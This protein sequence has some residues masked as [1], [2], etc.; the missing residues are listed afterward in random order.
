MATQNTQQAGVPE[1]DL[2]DRLSKSLRHAG[3]GTDE[4]AEHLGVDRKTVGNYKGGRTRPSVA[5]LR[6]WAMRCGVPFDWLAHGIIDDDGPDGPG[7]QAITAS[8]CT[9]LSPG[10]VLHGPWSAAA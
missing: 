3:V 7:G 5:V 2:A 4:M 6:V 8:R 10:R 9:A 1:W